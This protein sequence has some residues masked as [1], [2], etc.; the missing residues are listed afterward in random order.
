MSHELSDSEIDN[1]ISG[2][3][4]LCL[5]YQ[6]ED[7]YL[8]NAIIDKEFLVYFENQQYETHKITKENFNNQWSKLSLYRKKKIRNLI[9]NNEI[10]H[11]RNAIAIFLYFL[12]FNQDCN[13]V[14]IK[15]FDYYIQIHNGRNIRT[16]S[17]I[18]IHKFY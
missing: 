2:F 4:N 12:L 18:L 13:Q 6:Q 7:S 5:N 8:R 10:I 14:S 3:A 11:Q 15:P 16:L 9:A 17:Y 1:F